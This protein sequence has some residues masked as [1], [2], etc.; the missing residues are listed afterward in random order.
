MTLLGFA[1]SFVDGRVGADIF[2][3]A[4]IELWKIE[5]DGGIA[6][7][8]S[9]ALSEI[10]SSIFCVADM[11]VADDDFRED[12]ELNGD[13]LISEVAGLIANSSSNFT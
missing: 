10:L 8:D 4:Y 11:Y 5:R 3:E 7:G 13:Q 12:Y 1:R 6:A 9:S 2:S